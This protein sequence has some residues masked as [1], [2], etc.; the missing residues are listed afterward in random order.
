M[1]HAMDW[2]PRYKQQDYISTI[3]PTL[4]ACHVSWHLLEGARPG[5]RAAWEMVVSMDSSSYFMLSPCP[6][7]TLCLSNVSPFQ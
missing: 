3:L 2:R 1:T 6:Y 5:I 4:L 7:P